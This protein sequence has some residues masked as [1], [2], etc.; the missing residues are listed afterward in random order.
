VIDVQAL[1]DSV[2]LVDVVERYVKLR[3]TGSEYQGRCPFH[4]ERTPSFTVSPVKGFVH[5]FGCGA[6]HDVI[7]FVM[8]IAGVTFAEA[9]RQL[10]ARELASAAVRVERAQRCRSGDGEVWVPVVP[11]WPDAPALAA[12]TRVEL[13]NPKRGRSWRCEPI[14]ADA[15]HDAR[16]GLLGYVLRVQFE[17]G[18]KVTP[19]ITWCVGPDGSARWCVQ[20]FPRPRPLLGL[21]D[22]IARPNAPVLIVEGEKCRA[23]GAQALK[24]YVVMCWPGGTNGVRYVDFTPLEGRDLVLWPD[25]DEP[26]MKAMLGHLDACGVMHDG[27]A[28]QAWRAGCASV[29]LVDPTGQPKGWD[30]A[31][32]L[33]VDGWSVPQLAAW[34]ASRVRDVEVEA[35]PERRAA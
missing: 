6:H 27:V 18:K 34:A 3:Q 5:C 2:D 31:D 7:G 17:D 10:G 15:Y 14:R 25:A 30:L 19:Q 12:G 9:C 29:R 20:P 21:P 11:V 8:R 35:D 26:G 32:A 4:D 23:R 16:G 1:R 33:D 22:L 24:P 28:Q 13:Y